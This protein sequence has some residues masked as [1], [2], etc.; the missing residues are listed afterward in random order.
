MSIWLE[1]D[2]AGRPGLRGGGFVLVRF[3]TRGLWG[4]AR[5]YTITEVGEGD[6][7]RLMVRLRP[8]TA[9]L[10]HLKPGTRAIV[11]GPFRDLD[12]VEVPPGAPVLLLGA[13]A[14]VTPLRPLAADLSALGHDVVVVHR[15]TSPDQQLLAAE[16]REL[17]DRGAIVLHDIVGDRAALG[18]D[19]LEPDALAKLVPDL[20]ARE[21]VICTPPPLTARLVHATRELGVPAERLHV[22]VFSL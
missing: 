3:L 16:L 14:G 13:G 1:G 12:R 15:A 4:T 19:P 8:S 17:A 20:R 18:G 10:A 6:R 2:G 21:V 9:P 11:E 7:L 5:P 22:G